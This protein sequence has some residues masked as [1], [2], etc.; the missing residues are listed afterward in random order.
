[1]TGF[2]SSLEC[3]IT[4]QMKVEAE[5]AA[6]CL[7]YW[8]NSPAYNQQETEWLLV[9]FVSNKSCLCQLLC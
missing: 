4:M 1:M 8:L 9:Q 5:E 3:L 7:A 6:A 2:D